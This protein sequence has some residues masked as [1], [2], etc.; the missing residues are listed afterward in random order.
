LVAVFI[1]V[2][3]GAGFHVGSNNGLHGGH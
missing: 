3:L 2:D 1:G